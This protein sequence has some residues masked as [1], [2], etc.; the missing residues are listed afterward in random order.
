MEY[1]GV[2]YCTFTPIIHLHP[3]LHLICS[4]D[5]QM[6]WFMLVLYKQGVLMS[7][8]S[9]ECMNTDTRSALHV[10]GR[11][12]WEHVYL[13]NVKWGMEDLLSL[14]ERKI[15]EYGVYEYEEQ[16]AARIIY[17]HSYSIYGYCLIEFTF[18]CF[19]PLKLVHFRGTF[20]K[21]ND[22]K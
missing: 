10:S 21:L 9:N 7:M 11:K 15:Q 14:V 17:E 3:R 16:W 12:E 19:L 1:R 8:Y 4:A 6:S 2:P 22:E 5:W 18:L 13:L 20:L